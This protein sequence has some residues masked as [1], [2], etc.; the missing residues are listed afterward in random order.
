MK[1][2]IVTKDKPKD[3]VCFKCSLQFYKKSIFD[4]HQSLVHN[5]NDVRTAYIHKNDVKI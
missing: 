4:L 1:E 5:K 3:L 2:E